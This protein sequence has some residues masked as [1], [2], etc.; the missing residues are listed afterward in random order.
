MLDIE[1]ARLDA[2]DAIIAADGWC[3]KLPSANCQHCPILCF[4][5]DSNEDLLRKAKEWRA[6]HADA[7]R[8]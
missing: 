4:V 5:A 7:K 3:E 6:R 2:V 1:K 8:D